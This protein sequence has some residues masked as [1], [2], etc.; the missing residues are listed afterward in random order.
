MI[1]I[2][3]LTK[4]KDRVLMLQIPTNYKISEEKEAIEQLERVFGEAQ[5]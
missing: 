4:S 3:Q 1:E 2:P 5:L